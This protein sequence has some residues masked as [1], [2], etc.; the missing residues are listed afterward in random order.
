MFSGYP[1]TVAGIDDFYVTDQKLTVI[2]TTNSVFNMSLF[3]VIKYD[4]IVPYWIRVVVAT[5]SA[6]TAKEWHSLFYQYNSGTYNNQWLTV[7]YK[8]FKP[9]QPLPADVL[10][11]SEQIP[12]YYH[13]EDQTSVL[14]RGHWPSYNVPF[15]SDVYEMSGYPAVVHVHGPQHSYQLAPRGPIFRR[16]ADAPQD[17][18]GVRHFMRLNRFNITLPHS[19]QVD[20]LF[21]T[22]TSAIAARAD[23]EGVNVRSLGGAIDAK[24]VS[25]ELISRMAVT[26]IA[27][28]TNN[29]VSGDDQ[30]VFEWTGIW[31]NGSFPH[32]GQPTRF[33]FPWVNFSGTVNI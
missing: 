16:D 27:G 1:G 32:F 12:G 13:M 6:K 28:P 33:D 24:I 11:V 19:T 2:E 9:G 18:E 5:R 14:Q 8:L 30:P 10:W 23:L 31:N 15:Y 17:L 25:N 29:G 20:P 21:S 3:D 22:P 26:A 7:D 4:N